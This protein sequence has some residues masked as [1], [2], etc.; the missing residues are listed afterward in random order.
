M[1]LYIVI[2]NNYAFMKRY[3]RKSNV[4]IELPDNPKPPKE[5]FKRVDVQAPKAHPGE[6]PP[7]EDPPGENPK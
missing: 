6:N 5:Y 7:N 1:G 2:E 3:W 4:P